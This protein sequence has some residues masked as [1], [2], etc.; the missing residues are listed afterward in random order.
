MEFAEVLLAVIAA[1]QSTKSQ[2]KAVSEGFS[3][4]PKINMP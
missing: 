1:P 3:A 2:L 4:T